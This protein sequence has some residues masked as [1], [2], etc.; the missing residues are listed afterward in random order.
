LL[1]EIGKET[2][3]TAYQSKGIAGRVFQFAVM[4]GDADFNIIYNLRNALTI[5][6]P[7]HLA[8]LT[9]PKDVAE[10]MNRIEAYKGSDIV[11]AAFS[12]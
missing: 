4:R 10:L 9:A 7:R 1:L 8:A 11:R 5:K 6:P 3:H 2:P 12:R